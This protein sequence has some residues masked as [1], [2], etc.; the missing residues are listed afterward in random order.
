MSDVTFEWDRGKAV[1]NV[2]KH[3]VAFDEAVTAF[4]DPNG[5][6]W[7][8]PEHSIGEE[9]LLLLARS[10][11]HHLLMVVHCERGD[12]L[13]IRLISARRATYRE[14]MRYLSANDDR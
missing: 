10:E 11:D 8:D 1:E 6:I 7:P 2:R 14:L 9:R 12:G 4:E 3:G 5:V 13:R